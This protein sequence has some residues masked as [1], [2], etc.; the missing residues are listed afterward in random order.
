MAQFF[1]PASG[2]YSENN[3]SAGAYDPLNTG[4]DVLS[5][6][7]FLWQVSVCD[8]NAS[9][10]E[11]FEWDFYIPYP[12]LY[13]GLTS[14]YYDD[15]QDPDVCIVSDVNMAADVYGIAVYYSPSQTDFILEVFVLS[16][17]CI[18]VAV[19]GLTG[20][21]VNN[22][23]VINIDSDEQNHFAIVYEDDNGDIYCQTGSIV[24]TVLTL[25][26]TPLQIWTGGTMPDVTVHK[27]ASS[28]E[29]IVF[30]FIDGNGD[31]QV[32]DDDYVNYTSGGGCTP[33]LNYLYNSP[34]VY[35]FNRPRIASNPNG[36]TLL[37]TV[38]V[39]DNNGGDYFIDGFTENGSGVTA[40][41][42]N[43]GSLYPNYDITD[44]SNLRPVVTYDYAEDNI[45]VGWTFNNSAPV[46]PYNNPGDPD[47]ADYP[48]MLVCDLNGDPIT[49]TSYLE[50]PNVVNT[51]PST[52]TYAELSIAARFSRVYTYFTYSCA[53]GCD[54]IYTKDVPQT[55]S[56]LR[57]APG[58]TDAEDA[59][60]YPNPFTDEFT[61]HFNF[62]NVHAIVFD[63]TGKILL[64]A[65]GN[66]EGINNQLRDFA[67]N[68]TE[69][70]YVNY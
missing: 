31:V 44:A 56:Q 1:V 46:Y 30:T 19:T 64:S 51:N 15:A 52:E 8:A 61:V 13:H 38:V 49:H 11:A 70:I 5:Q 59:L 67:K 35:S 24:T 39:E 55:A 66:E 28:Y 23:H 48:V 68:L 29:H 62:D 7:D 4:N 26:C 37:W 50:V 58:V 45:F 65:F 25:N 32:Y 43:D 69:G 63:V 9:G 33:A 47:E 27:G 36:S 3:F 14:F 40:R 18:S 60:L 21:N 12:S 53:T 57:A 17:P 10:S 2:S 6:G 42:Y 22:L 54:D 16:N 20:G 41:I 34:P